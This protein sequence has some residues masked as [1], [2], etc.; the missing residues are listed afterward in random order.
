MI[1][2]RN[3]EYTFRALGIEPIVGDFRR[4][5]QLFVSMGFFSFRQREGTPKL[6]VPP[7]GMTK[8][9]TKFFY[10]KVATIAAK[11]QFQNMTGT[12][13]TENISVPRADTVD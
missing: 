8:W 11:L 2:V 1:R 10:V 3:F 6:M 9:K 7:K 13:I 5:Y 12:I 4:L